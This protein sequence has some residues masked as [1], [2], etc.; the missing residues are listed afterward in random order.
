MT[1]DQEEQFAKNP[2]FIGLKFP[3]L[4]NPETLEKHYIG[5]MSKSAISLMNGML[6]MDPKERSTAL[7]ALAHQYFDS[8]RDDEVTELVSS[9]KEKI[10]KEIELPQSKPEASR[11]KDLSRRRTSTDKQQTEGISKNPYSLPLGSSPPQFKKSN[12]NKK[13]LNKL[14]KDK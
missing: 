9:N 2:R 10:T 12:N 4:K 8:I 3:E 7:D 5:K 13:Q 11:S 14:S 6:K 1:P